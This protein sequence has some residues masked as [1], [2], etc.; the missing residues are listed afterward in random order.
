MGKGSEQR[1]TDLK[2]YAAN[3]DAIYAK[4]PPQWPPEAP[5]EE[6]PEKRPEKPPLKKDPRTWNEFYTE[7][8]KMQSE[9]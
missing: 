7:V 3:W 9:L 5:P 1:P 4:Q 2:K 6:E 8:A